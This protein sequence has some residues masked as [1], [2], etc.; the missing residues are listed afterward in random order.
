[1]AWE[2]TTEVWVAIGFLMFGLLLIFLEIVQPGFFIAVPGGVLFLAGALG[3]A[4]PGIMFGVLGWILWPVILAVATL[5]NLW[6]YKRWVPP[7]DKPITLSIDS[8]PGEEG[9]VTVAVTKDHMLGKVR[10]KGT[11]WSA[12]STIDDIPVGTRV[13]VVR[14]EGVHIV[15][16]AVDE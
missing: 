12:H 7:G 8:L 10:I 2:L 11:T 9:E 13:R 5:L 14:S 4:F 15:V 6:V 1:M 16:E 3:I